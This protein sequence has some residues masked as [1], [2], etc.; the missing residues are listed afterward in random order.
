MSHTT[1]VITIDG[2]S[3][4]GKGTVGRLLANQ[5]EWHFLDSGA[6]YRSLALVLIRKNILSSRFDLLINEARALEIKF[7]TD[8]EV[9][10]V[11]LGGEDISTAIR[12][13]ECAKLASEVATIPEV[14]YVLIEQQR[15][16]RREPGLVAD[17]RDMGTIIFPDA[18][19]K[20]FL[21]A[22]REERAHRRLR[23]LKEMGIMSDFQVTLEDL[24]VRDERDCDRATAPLVVANGAVIIDTTQLTVNEAVDKI[25]ERWKYYLSY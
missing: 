17:G 5:L 19:L 6:I 2:P 10:L 21:T 15:K 20:I 8:G 18:P 11:M 13:K 9:K 3:G 16:Q 14:R 22:E 25:I 24:A 7:V 12:R 23:Q 4:S 1:P